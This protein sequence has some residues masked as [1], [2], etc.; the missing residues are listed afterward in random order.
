MTQTFKHNQHSQLSIKQQLNQTQHVATHNII[1]VPQNNNTPLQACKSIN[2]CPQLKHKSVT[3][4]LK[5]KISQ[6]IHN[7]HQHKKKTQKNITTTHI[8]TTGILK[9]PNKNLPLQTNYQHQQFNSIFLHHIQ[10]PSTKST[11]DVRRV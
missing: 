4:A 5:P 1:H 11:N 10:T 6:Q 3:H 8:P 2:T 9:K 7:H